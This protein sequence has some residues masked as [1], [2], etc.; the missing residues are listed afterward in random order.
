MANSSST[1]LQRSRAPC[2]WPVGARRGHGGDTGSTWGR[3]HRGALQESGLKWGSG[4]SPAG[5]DD[6]VPCP[7]SSLTCEESDIVEWIC[8][9]N[10]WMTQVASTLPSRSPLDSVLSLSPSLGTSPLSSHRPL[11]SRAPPGRGRRAGQA[12]SGPGEGESVSVPL[13]TAPGPRRRAGRSG[14]WRAGGRDASPGSTRARP[15]S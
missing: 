9:M 5:H 11:G 15:P 8:R 7:N 3:G 6:Y 1:R 10:G 12:R 14:V 13:P 2:A 4:P